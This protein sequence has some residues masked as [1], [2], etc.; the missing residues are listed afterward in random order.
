MLTAGTRI[1]PHEIIA[2]LDSE[3]TGDVYRAHDTRLDRTVVIKV[4][5]PHWGGGPTSRARFERDTKIVASLS[6]PA[7]RALHDIGRE[8]PRP[9]SQPPS[10]GSSTA[11]D[12]APAG[13][14]DDQPASADEPEIDYLV[15]EHL[16]GE[17]V[18]ARLA[19]AST[20]SGVRKGSAFRVDEALAIATQ[21]ADA[22]DKAHRKGLVHG[23]LKP[24]NVFLVKG[25]QSSDPPLAKLLALGLTGVDRPV[26]PGSEA[27][28]QSPASGSANVSVLPT[29]A[30]GN[31]ALPVADT[32][33]QLE[34]KAPEQIDGR[35][36]DARTDIFAFGVLLYEMLTG[37]KAFEGKSPAVLMAAIM[38]AEPDP[39]LALQPQASPALD[40]VIKR[41]LAKDP[42]DRWQTAHDLLI[43]L[44]WVTGLSAKAGKTAAGKTP[45]LIRRLA[46][47]AAVAVAALAGPA[48]F[49]FREAEPV[50]PFQFRAPVVGLNTADFSIS[51]DA[52]QLAFVARP[53]TAEPPSLFVR[54]VG[55]VDSRRLAGTDDATLPFWSPDSRFIGFVARGKL[56]MVD[57]G[58]GRQREI[59]DVPGFSGATWN[60]Q[61]T[62]LFGSP[63]GLF[64]VPAE[65]GSAE[66]ISSLGKDETGHLWP[67]F[68]PDGRHYVYLAWSVDAGSRAV[69]IGTLDSKD[70]TRL[71]AAE[72]NVVYAPSASGRGPGY[73][74]YHR[75]ATIFARPFDDASQSF[76]GDPVQIAGGASYNTANG[77]GNFDV[78]QRDALV[79]FQGDAGGGVTAGRGLTAPQVQFGWITKE[80]LT[81]GPAG[82][83]GTYGDMD[84]SPDG[85][86]VAVTRQDGA[87][88]DIWVI[89]WQRAGVPTRVTSD[90][91]DDVNPVWSSDGARVA[92]T[93]YRKGNADIY[94]MNA[95]ALGPETP[96]LE[97]PNHESIEAW[98]RDGNY[99][100]F[101]FGNGDGPL[102]IYAMPLTGDRKP[103]PVVQGAFEKDEPQFSYDG[104]WLAYTSN[105]SGSFQV[106]VIS[107]PKAEQRLQITRDGGGQPRWREDAR[108]IYYRAP[109]N[110]IMVVD[111]TPGVRI[112]AM[113]PRLLFG[114]IVRNPMTLNPVRHQLSVTP[115]GRQFLL[116]IPPVATGAQGGTVQ[117][118]TTYSPE[119]RQSGGRGAIF[120]GAARGGRG[121]AAGEAG[122]TV[123]RNWTASMPK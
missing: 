30:P 63:K 82:A 34:Y 67:C 76:V 32:Q 89:D 81:T 80:G 37:R 24:A 25:G 10:S 100:A 48:V 58:T 42:D 21:I 105:E 51:P 64:R 46:S 13:A 14:G 15:L 44:K 29:M 88:S 86:F 120:T 19:R 36:T 87:T 73:L 27:P 77:R 112:D 103:F 74:L 97:S 85:R 3:G 92:Y 23:D 107:F 75:D 2:P 62:I 47:A 22:L 33:Q 53:N 50:E 66:A 40:H 12:G 104:K 115:D 68:L 78:S 17:S 20:G 43:Q 35:D 83:A 94:L 4:L 60:Q 45:R 6:H 49:Y 16:E 106:N 99:I 118:S 55:G 57:A 90:P 5:S 39:L 65:G 113:P 28:V 18:A 116:R 84:L 110:R 38:T 121:F 98:S 102:D 122:L 71:M 109:D 69:Y 56:K 108:E 8:R 119:T 41:C 123:I 70:R 26:Q 91:G 101:L 96:L 111:F 9:A 93:T 117:G 7:I 95:N 31:Q 54:P 52:R 72:S 59:A 61:G 1:G 114:P 11:D 79:Y